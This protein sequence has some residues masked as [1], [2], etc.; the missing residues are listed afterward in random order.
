MLPADEGC[1]E[2]TYGAGHGL[3]AGLLGEMELYTWL[4]GTVRFS[5][6]Q[7]GGTMR[8]TCDN[9]I[10]VPVGSNDFAPLVREYTK[11][12]RLDY[13]LADFGLKLMPLDIPVFLSAGLSIGAPLFR[14]AYSQDERIVSPEGALFPGFVASRSNGGG[15]IRDTKLRS[16]VRAG[17]G[18]AFTLHNHAELSPELSYT[19]PLTNVALGDTWKIATLSAGLS[20]AWRID[21]HEEEPPLPVEPP[22]P[23]PPPPPPAPPVASISTTTDAEINITETFVT[24]TFPLLP[25]IFFEKD[26]S[27]LPDKYRHMEARDTAAF[28]ENGLPR[29]TMGIYYHILDIAGKRLQ[30]NPQ[31]TVTLSGST[32]DKD[33]EK[34][35]TALALARA[36]AV[37]TYFTDVWGIDAKRIKVTQQKLPPIPSTQT[38][39]E[40]DEENRRVDMTSSSDELFRPVVHERLSEF[41]ITPPTLELALRGDGASALASWSMAVRHDGEDVASFAGAGPPPATVRWTLGDSVAARVREHDSLRALLTVTDERGNIGRSEIAIPVNKRQNSFEIGRLSLI[42][43]DFDRSDIFLFNQRMIKRFVAEAITPSS[44]VVIT[45]STDR[46]GEEKHNIELSAAR[47]ESVK[48]ILLSQSPTYEKLEARGIGEAPDLYDNMLP[49]GRFYCRTVAVEVTTPVK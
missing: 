48:A 33:A 3:A 17:V 11:V 31:V 14:A 36:N 1:G 35:N 25:Y 12:V 28:T 41:A 2:F 15:D 24:E 43:F 32:D 45:G 19:H 8:A 29:K 37:K 4:R 49:E 26:S 47:A 42:V 20:L 40:G 23:P 44:S 22:P 13:A 9:G 30:A 16:A 39:A 46:L 5:Y 21:L 34:D 27:R 10:I 18:Y 6:A 38:L 7:L